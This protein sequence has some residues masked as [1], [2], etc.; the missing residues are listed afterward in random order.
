MK[1]FLWIMNY[2]QFKSYSSLGNIPIINFNIT[3]YYKN[4]L[5][6]VYIKYDFF[7]GLLR[8]YCQQDT[9]TLSETWKMQWLLGEIHL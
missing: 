2:A 9:C 8:R 1:L 4:D 5:L 6:W 3:T 7:F